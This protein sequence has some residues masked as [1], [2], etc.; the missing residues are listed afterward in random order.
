M[1]AVAPGTATT[2]GWD[3]LLPSAP[4]LL[5]HVAVA[6]LVGGA[7]Q[8]VGRTTDLPRQVRLAAAR[9]RRL[10]VPG[11]GVLA[12]LLAAPER[13]L[14]RPQRAA[15]AAAAVPTGPR[16]LVAARTVVRRGP[17]ALLPA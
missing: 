9:V 7:L 16:H 13:L 12:L 5:A 4:M 8:T 14:H 2:V 15:A 3:D 17:P 10:A 1:P 6:A 11:S